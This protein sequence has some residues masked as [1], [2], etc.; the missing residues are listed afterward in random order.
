MTAQ[1]DV[2]H[3]IVLAIEGVADDLDTLGSSYGRVVELLEEIGSAEDPM[4]SLDERIE[5]ARRLADI[6]DATASVDKAITELGLPFAATVRP[7][8]RPRGARP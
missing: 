4:A 5:L 6:R 7:T 1:H 3:R 8:F 2:R